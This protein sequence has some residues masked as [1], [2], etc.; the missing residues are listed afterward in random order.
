[1][2]FKSRSILVN[3]YKR[4][5]LAIFAC[6]VLALRWMFRP[7]KRGVSPG[8]GEER[9]SVEENTWRYPLGQV[10]AL[11]NKGG[12][13]AHRAGCAPGSSPP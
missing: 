9:A 4:A 2:R 10:A 8:W 3:G 7:S 6:P 5:W 1:M 11:T 13:A 12:G